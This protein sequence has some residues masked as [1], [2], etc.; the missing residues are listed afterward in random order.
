MF[1]AELYNKNRIIAHLYFWFVEALKTQFF[2]QKYVRQRLEG[3]CEEIISWSNPDMFIWRKLWVLPLGEFLIDE[4]FT[5]YPNGLCLKNCFDIHV[6]YKAS[7][8]SLSYY[9]YYF[10]SLFFV[11]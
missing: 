8:A 10:H 2:A 5:P 11:T 4:G 7:T 6:G 1:N 3:T 9:M